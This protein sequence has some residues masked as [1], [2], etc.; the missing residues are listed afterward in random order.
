MALVGA[1]A[2]NFVPRVQDARARTRTALQARHMFPHVQNVHAGL[3]H[4]TFPRVLVDALM[5]AQLSN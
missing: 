3:G 4:C 2:E 1:R 5:R